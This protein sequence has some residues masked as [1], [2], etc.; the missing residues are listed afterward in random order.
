MIPPARGVRRLGAIGAFF[1]LGLAL[2]RPAGAQERYRLEAGQWQQQTHIDPATPEGEIQTIRRKI[3]E[4][5]AKDAQDLA[6]DWI[7]RHPNHPLLVEAY[8]LRGDAR[9][10]QGKEYKA[11]YDY[12]YV[13]RQYPAS[14]QFNVALEREYE[15]ARLY[16]AGQ[17]RKF[18]GMRI[19][20]AGDEAEEIFIR[21]QERSPGSEL[22]EKASLALGD[23]YFNH[24]QMTSA[25]EAYGLF[26]VNYPRSQYRERARL[27]VIQAN[28]ARFKG[29]SFDPTGLI[30]AAERIRQYQKEYPAAAERIGADALLVRINESLAMKIYRSAEWYKDRG[31]QWSAVTMYRRVIRDYP[32]TAA[33]KVAMQQLAAWHQAPLAPLS[34]GSTAPSG[35]EPGAILRVPASEPASTRPPE[36]KP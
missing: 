16:A 4:G 9:V 6:S 35:R 28:L 31:R 19:L 23:Y 10:A 27:R 25:A 5:N 30:E 24:G 3:A 7:T 32:Q 15:I 2:T 18:L 29:P 22:G 20:P 33:A 21:I 34:E 26:V 17:K 14:E 12:E 36:V 1:V 13:I 11:L 8:L